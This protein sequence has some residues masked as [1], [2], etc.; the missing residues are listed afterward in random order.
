MRYCLE[1]LERLLLI[2]FYKQHIFVRHLKSFNDTNN[3]G[4][5]I[6]DTQVIAIDKIKTLRRDVNH[7]T[8]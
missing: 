5:D 4:V 6:T 2:F 3:L 1:G 8:E 7:D